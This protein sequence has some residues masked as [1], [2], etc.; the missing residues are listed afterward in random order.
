[1]V[2]GSTID[3]L[4]GLANPALFAIAIA[5]P[6]PEHGPG[7]LGAAAAISAPIMSGGVYVPVGSAYGSG[8]FVDADSALRCYNFNRYWQ[9]SM[10]GYSY[11]VGTCGTYA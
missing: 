2:Q 6:T 8:P 11:M 10:L 7:A 9:T 1:G 4:V 3:L 5:P